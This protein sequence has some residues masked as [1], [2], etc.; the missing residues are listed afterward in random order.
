[1]LTRKPAGTCK[2]GSAAGAGGT[3]AVGT[4][5]GV[6]NGVAVGATLGAVDGAEVGPPLEPGPGGCTIGAGLV[7]PPPAQAASATAS[8]A[9]PASEARS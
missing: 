2:F 5:V 9:A 8:N 6:G 1:M 7:V 4:G 3:L